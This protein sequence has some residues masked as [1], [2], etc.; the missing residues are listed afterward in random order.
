[1]HHGYS[2]RVNVALDLRL[3]L[4]RGEAQIVGALQVQPETAD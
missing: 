1:M 4:R 3:V 2:P